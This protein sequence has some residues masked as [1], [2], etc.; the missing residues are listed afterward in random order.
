[1]SLQSRMVKDGRK[2]DTRE[3]DTTT[4]FH[5]PHLLPPIFFSGKP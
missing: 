3:N 2:K 4:T 1:M 5:F